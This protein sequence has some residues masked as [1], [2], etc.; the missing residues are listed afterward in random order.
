MPHW[1]WACTPLGAVIGTILVPQWVVKLMGPAT[2]ADAARGPFEALMRFSQEH[3]LFWTSI[4]LFL[5]TAIALMLFRKYLP[6]PSSVLSLG[7]ESAALPLLN[8]AAVIGFGGVVKATPIFDA[9]K[10]LV[11]DSGLNPL[12]SMV[13][14]VNVVAGLVGSASGGLGIF[15]QNLAPHYLEAGVDPETMHRLAAIAS[16]GLDSLPH[17]G[18]VITFLTVMRLTHKQAYKGIAVVTIVVPLIA[19]A[20]VLAIAI[21]GA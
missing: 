8:T 14:A 13:V 19:L 7:A 21:A 10:T 5:G 3:P 12:A 17:S 15:M 1:A 9:F 16:G 18:A 2:G 6:K 11:V 20:V 4:A